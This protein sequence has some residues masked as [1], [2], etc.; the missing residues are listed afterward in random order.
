MGFG[1]CFVIGWIISFS[2][3]FFLKDLSKFA[4]MYSLGSLTAICSTFFLNGPI[5]QIKS[6]FG[7]DR[8]FATLFYLG[9]L[10]LTLGLALSG[11][12]V[13]WVVAALVLQVIAMCWYALSY[14]PYGRE[15][16]FE[17]HLFFCAS[18]PGV[19]SFI[20]SLIR[21]YRLVSR[22][23]HVPSL[24]A[25]TAPI[26]RYAQCVNAWHARACPSNRRRRHTDPKY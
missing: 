26:L 6:M 12:K 1:I 24:R 9:T 10:A 4:I 17:R 16:T 20:R 19:C 13:G 8:I 23:C 18:H 2:S 7:Q 11:Q 21:S 5:A 15:S 25:C 22:V 3:L 14:I